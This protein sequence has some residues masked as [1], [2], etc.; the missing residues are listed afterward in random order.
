[1]KF[2]KGDYIEGI[3]HIEITDRDRVM[4]G[5]VDSI[6][7]DKIFI[8]ADDGYNGARG[9]MVNLEGA[10]YCNKVE[11]WWV[12]A[13][14]EIPIGTVVRHFKD[15]LYKILGYAEHVDGGK[16][17]IYTALYAPYKTY[18]REYT[19][20]MS[21]VDSK[22]YPDVEQKYRFEVVE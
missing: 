5:Y 2:N 15:K 11:E 19:E 14:R 1:M 10:H 12:A 3:E 21:K 20:F 4:R 8:Q 16:V 22:K 9:T 7:G 13:K 6:N 17:V 18:V